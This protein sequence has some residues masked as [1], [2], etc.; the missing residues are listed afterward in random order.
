MPISVLRIGTVKWCLSRAVQRRGGSYL[1]EAAV[2]SLTTPLSPASKSPK[3]PTKVLFSTLTSA[4]LCQMK[5]PAQMDIAL[6]RLYD[7]GL[8][9]WIIGW[10]EV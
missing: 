9:G 8:D 4:T 10:G 1:S 5:L 6:W 2:S 3:G 7:S